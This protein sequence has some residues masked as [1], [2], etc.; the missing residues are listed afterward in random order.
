MTC[1]TQITE[2]SASLVRRKVHLLSLKEAVNSEPHRCVNVAPVAGLVTLHSSCWVLFR[3][4]AAGVN[5]RKVYT[6]SSIAEMRIGRD[7]CGRRKSTDV[8]SESRQ[9][10][11]ASNSPRVTHHFFT[12]EADDAGPISVHVRT[13][14][15]AGVFEIQN[16][17][18]Q[19]GT[20]LDVAQTHRLIA[21]FHTSRSTGR[22]RP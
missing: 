11:E 15:A 9:I 18:V 10:P 6:Q 4:Q 2:V 14:L 8:S 22:T 5:Q 7:S 1:R 21:K 3:G 16:I 17:S 12:L 19:R 20:R 13:G